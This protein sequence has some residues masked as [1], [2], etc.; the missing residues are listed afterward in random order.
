MRSLFRWSFL[1]ALLV[2]CGSET[3]STFN[4]LNAG[5]DGGT[6]EDG[7]PGLGDGF[8]DGGGNSDGIVLARPYGGAM[9]ERLLVVEEAFVARGRGVLVL[10]KFTAPSSSSAPTRVKLRRPDGTEA[11]VAATVEVSHMRGALAP[12]AMYRLPE[13]TTEDVPPATELWSL[14]DDGQ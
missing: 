6:D 5:K 1:L 14:D 8:S 13:S 11:I 2:A 9:A 7:S 4:D 3:E 12:W 10:P